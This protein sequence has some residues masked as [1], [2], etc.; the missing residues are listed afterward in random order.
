MRTLDAWI[1]QVKPHELRIGG[2]KL[3][4][5]TRVKMVILEEQ[6]TISHGYM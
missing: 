2:L 4:R 6:G 3:R 5:E 1:G